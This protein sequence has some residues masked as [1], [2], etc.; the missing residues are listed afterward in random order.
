[1]VNNTLDL[2]FIPL[3]FLKSALAVA[4]NQLEPN[5]SF[6]LE[7]TSLSPKISL[8]SYQYLLC[9]AILLPN[10]HNVSISKKT[11]LPFFIA[12]PKVISTLKAFST[13]IQSVK[14]VSSLHAE[15]LEN[16][17]EDMVQDKWMRSS[18][19]AR[20]GI[21]AW[22]ETRLRLMWEAALLKSNA[23]VRWKITMSCAKQT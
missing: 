22:R 19:V 14:D 16:H 2:D 11:A 17:A 13:V 8:M 20:H 6:E 5:Q 21:D 7:F 15:A 10:R 12:L 23:L 4:Q 1:L 3:P 9:A 18:F